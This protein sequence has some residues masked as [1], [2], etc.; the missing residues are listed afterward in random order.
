MHILITGSAGFIGY[1]LTRR[2]VDD[3]HT[4]FAIDNINSYYDMSLKFARLN[5]L[6]VFTSEN[7]DPIVS[8]NYPTLTF[9]R[10]DITDAEK[11]TALF[12]AKQFDAVV[13]LA[14]QA[15]VRYS[16]EHP[17]AYISSNISGTL[18][19]LEAVQRYPVK[20]V[21]YASSSSVYGLNAAQPFSENVAADRPVSLYA[22]SKRA[23]ELL[24]HTYAHLYNIPCT[25][26]R[27]FT[28]Y[29]PWGRPDMSPMLFAK[30]IIAG[31][32]IRVF[33]GG[34]MKRDFTYIDDIVEGIARVIPVVP[35]ANAESSAPYAIYNI[36]HGSPVN[37][38][39]FIAALEDALGIKAKTEMLP[40]Q[41]G[42][43][44]STWADCAALQ[45][46]T[47]YKSATDITDGIK[48]FAAWYRD[49]YR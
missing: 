11:L 26:L 39:D 45:K 38:M 8:K 14:A 36:G 33:N 43:V 40:M 30:A 47:G 27:F 35:T 10:L 17:D 20:H 6:G 16:I 37:L 13:H 42:D 41:Q 3:G 49:F 48:K 15:G 23:C 46:A 7:D 31:E 25:G 18:N 34:N 44:V 24:A 32:P 21:V 19:L 2:L 4:I 29:G 22:A 12:A 28:V 1:H 5:E 9:Q